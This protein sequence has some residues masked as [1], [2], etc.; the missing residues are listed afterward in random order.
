MI[1]TSTNDTIAAIATPPG[2]GGVGIVRLSGPEALEIAL[3]LFKRPTRRTQPASWQ[4]ESHRLYYGH[5]I[6][7]GTGQI[8]DEVLLA[9]MHEPRS[10]T[11]EEVVEIQTHGGP[12]LLRRILDAALSEGARLANPGE[13]TLRAFLNGRIDLA[14]AEAVMDMIGA[15]TDEGLKL[16]VDQ[17]QGRLSA[18]VQAARQETLGA[19]A[20][21]EASIDFPEE[22]VPSPDPD[23]LRAGIAAAFARIER[24]LA[25][26]EQGRIYREGLRAAIIGRPNVGKSS[27]LNALLR[28]DRAI[29]TPIAGTTRDTVSEFAN[30]RGIPVQLIDTAGIAETS[31]PVEQIGV[32]RSREAAATSDL[33]LLVLDGSE[34]LT[35][36]DE[37]VS[38][39][40][41]TLGFSSD[42]ASQANA[43][44]NGHADLHGSAV[45]RPII[46]VVNKSDLPERLR[47]A[48]VETLWP[49]APVVRTSMVT[50]SGLDTLEEQMRA[51]ALAGQAT[52]S[53][54]E[55]LV[56]NTRH[57]DALRRA[58][59]HLSAA[60]NTL[61]AGLP[62]DF[63]SIDLHGA[64]DALGEIT[65]ET[66]TE[67]LL[68]RIF[69]DFCIGK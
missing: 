54:Q 44:S 67:D 4:P 5:I 12:L 46:V 58:A 36:Q 15:R 40:L 50:Q 7:P 45:G 43:A 65:G 25:G 64:V 34:P 1:R 29:V 19:L 56:A 38:A 32:R 10:Y 13:M 49:G 66:A 33:V 68:E 48:D 47:L 11:A 21:I 41:Q 62:L 17:L 51:L 52:P 24:L 9:Y 35:A 26:A 55:T 6:Q 59:E 16:A 8:L 18:E 23:V 63:V 69:H 30:V 31:D 37:E 28:L 57:R 14:Q 39:V 20:M 3:K 53:E 61:D 60:S 42:H 27:L 2:I 22:E